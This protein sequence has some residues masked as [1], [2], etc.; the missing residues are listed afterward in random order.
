[1]PVP[2]DGPPGRGIRIQGPDVILGS[3]ASP[4][5]FR[6]EANG[7]VA[8]LARS[9]A[10]EID[11]HQHCSGIPL[12]VE[13]ASYGSSPNCGMRFVERTN[14]KILPDTAP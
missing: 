14:L 7:L 5:Y 11:Q 8:L 3:S 2:A 12:S 10:L 13:R 9:L 4:N 1:V 6:N